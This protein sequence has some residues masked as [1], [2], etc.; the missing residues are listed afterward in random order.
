MSLN[1]PL[2]KLA[3]IPSG[4]GKMA[5]VPPITT[6]GMSSFRQAKIEVTGRA[7]CAIGRGLKGASVITV[8][9]NGGLGLIMGLAG[10]ADITIDG[11]GAVS[12]VA[13]ASGTASITV[14]GR[15]AI[16]INAGLSGTAAITVNGRAEVT[17]LEWIKGTTVEEMSAEGI[18]Q[19]LWNSLAERYTTQ[20]TM[21]RKLN[22]AGGGS[23][24]IDIAAA[25]L[26]AAEVTPI[27]SDIQKVRGQD[28]QG[29]GSEA[30]PWGPV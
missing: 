1:G 14:T 9:G 26:A 25:V 19:A 3:A 6:G 29:V 16:G 28:L 2:N 30:S 18:A 4:Y 11:R 15:G 23:S 13:T 8:T 10:T 5:T 22:D 7:N 21:G 12:I 24:P 27:S 20:G 17:L